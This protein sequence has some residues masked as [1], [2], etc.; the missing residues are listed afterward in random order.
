MVGVSLY[1]KG[2]SPSKGTF[3]LLSSPISPKSKAP[4]NTHESV[5]AFKRPKRKP[6]PK[7]TISGRGTKIPKHKT[8]KRPPKAAVLTLRRSPRLKA[9]KA[10][11]LQEAKRLEEPASKPREQDSAKSSSE[12]DRQHVEGTPM[13]SP[14]KSDS[15]SNRRLRAS[16][17]PIPKLS[18]KQ[19]SQSASRASTKPVR[20]QRRR[21]WPVSTPSRSPMQL[22]TVSSTRHTS[23]KKR[24]NTV[25]SETLTKR[26]E[27]PLTIASER[28]LSTRLSGSAPGYEADTEAASECCQSWDSEDAGRT[29]GSPLWIESLN[30]LEEFLESYQFENELISGRKV[31]SRLH[32]NE[33][34]RNSSLAFMTPSD[35]SPGSSRDVVSAAS[36]KTTG[37][38]WF[39]WLW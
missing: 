15:G 23:P 16:P 13:R 14:K 34:V 20:R 2:S 21:S 5:K 22:K 9:T 35:R 8:K 12:T 4:H 17:R 24:S 19:R 37:G 1:I 29:Y 10:K 11:Q 32:Q 38:G 31:S 6:A 3:S 27:T 18:N 39:G 28:A 30:C 7:A 25:D 26:L 36:K 33:S